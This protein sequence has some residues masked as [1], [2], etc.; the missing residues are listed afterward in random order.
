VI[1]VGE[2]DVASML[3]VRPPQARDLLTSALKMDVAYLPLQPF[4]SASWHTRV[5][6]ETG[7]V[8]ARA[9]CVHGACGERLALPVGR[10]ESRAVTTT[11][12][13]RQPTVVGRA[14]TGQPR[15]YRLARPATHEAAYRRLA[16]AILGLDVSTLGIELR[17]AS[18]AVQRL[19][20]ST[21]SAS[22]A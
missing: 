10:R 19:T 7:L 17:M 15:T 13:L 2:P 12:T 6:L 11:R 4:L 1:V 18:L 3:Q 8:R 20:S 22:A 9:H 14:T 5:P 21:A 16:V